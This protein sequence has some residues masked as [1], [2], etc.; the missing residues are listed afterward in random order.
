MGSLTRAQADEAR[1]RYRAA[2][3]AA[4]LEWGERGQTRSER[5]AVTHELLARGLPTIT[6]LAQEYGVTKY[7]MSAVIRDRSLHEPRPRKRNVYHPPH[8][9]A[10]A[11]RA[12]EAVRYQY[13]GAE[14]VAARF[15]VSIYT[16]RNWR[17]KQRQEVA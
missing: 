14:A 15:N 16:L 10:A 3:A 6:T 17:R 1:A 12:W 2:L 8:H 11:L 13:G 9:R 5:C 4:G 7:K